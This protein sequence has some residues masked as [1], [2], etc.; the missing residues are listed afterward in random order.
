[1][2]EVEVEAGW[3]PMKP[4]EN[5]QMDVDRDGT[6]IERSWGEMTRSNSTPL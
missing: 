3:V 6:R 2:N 4:P 1:M 5:R